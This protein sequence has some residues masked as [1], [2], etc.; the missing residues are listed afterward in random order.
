MISEKMILL[1]KN[2]SVIRAMFEEGNRLAAE[3]GRENVFDF[4]LG[5]PSIPSPSAVN[6]AIID[7]VQNENPLSLH[8]YMTNAGYPAVREAIAKSLNKKHGTAFS[9]KNIIMS[10]GAAG[11]L[12]VALKTLLNPGDEVIV[13]SPYFVEYGNYVSNFDGELVVV[14]ASRVDFQPNMETMRRAI[15]DKTKAVIVNTPN[16]PTGVVYSE[17]T[18]KKLALLLKEKSKEHGSP[19]YIVSDEPYRELVYDDTEVPFITKFYKNTIVCYSWS[20][21]LSLP[22]QRIGYVLVPSEAEDYELIFETASIA[23]RI[24]GF[25]NAPALIQKVVAKCLEQETDIEAYNA[26]RVLLYDE[27]S[28]LGFEIVDPKGAFYLWVKTPGDDKDFVKA[29]VKYNILIVPGSAFTCGGYVRIAYCVSK[30]TIEKSL[31]AFKK[32]ANELGIKRKVP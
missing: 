12:N 31:P 27:L 2:N 21:S 16:N 4:S 19:I 24:L 28:A 26:N 20:K 7:I 30:Q 13:I 29:A 11:G 14:P 10:A 25:V 5:N 17:D 23:T 3:Y 15:T 22:G 1:A 18:I 8:G 32:L 6:E 9:E